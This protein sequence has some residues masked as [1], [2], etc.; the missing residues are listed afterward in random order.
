M[1]PLK[2]ISNPR[3]T[4]SNVFVGDL[5]TGS[6]LIS[7]DGQRIGLI[8]FEFTGERKTVSAPTIHF[9]TH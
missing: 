1:Q 4:G 5:Y 7:E 6:I 8:D 3:M 9:N 2:T